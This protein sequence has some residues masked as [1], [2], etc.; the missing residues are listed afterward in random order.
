MASEEVDA[1]VCDAE[2][3]WPSPGTSTSERLYRVNRAK[4]T[5]GFLAR[6]DAESA[7]RKSGTHLVCH[8]GPRRCSMGSGT[9][10]IGAVGTNRPLAQCGQ[11]KR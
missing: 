10:A 6:A 8:G 11:R 7:T 5:S 4:G 9:G 1:G 2:Q 3:W